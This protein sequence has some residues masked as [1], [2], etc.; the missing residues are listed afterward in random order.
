MRTES[1]DHTQT[2]RRFRVRLLVP[3][4][5]TA[6]PGFLWFGVADSVI[7]HQKRPELMPLFDLSFIVLL[8]VL[9]TIVWLV[10]LYAYHISGV[11]LKEDGVE[12]TGLSGKRVVPYT[13]II[14]LDWSYRGYAILLRGNDSKLLGVISI[15]NSGISTIERE[16]SIR[17]GLDS[18]SS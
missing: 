9:A 2:G 15:M 17:A 10:I 12:I 11:I 14:R 7:E 6:V 3:V 18:Q 8:G 4:L 13:E 1:P 5:A 16:L